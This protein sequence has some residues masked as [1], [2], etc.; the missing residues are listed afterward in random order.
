MSRLW[1]T[2]TTSSGH[3]DDA[4]RDLNR[5][6]RRV[7]RSDGGLSEYE[8]RFYGV[9]FIAFAAIACVFY[10]SIRGVR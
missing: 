9:A 10:L 1:N 5:D 3:F 2:R 4:K 8:K 6:L 7:R